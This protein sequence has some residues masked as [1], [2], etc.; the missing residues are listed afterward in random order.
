MRGEKLCIRACGR[1]FPALL[2][3]CTEE[4]KV[5]VKLSYMA[6]A[7]EAFEIAGLKPGSIAFTRREGRAVLIQLRGGWLKAYILAEP[8]C[9]SLRDYSSVAA[10][11]SLNN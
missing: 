4:L 9:P 1:T 10:L 6:E 3:G 11:Y 7:L 8:F 2:R 5:S